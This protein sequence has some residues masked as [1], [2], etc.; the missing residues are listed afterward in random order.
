MKTK[1][2]FL[3][4]ALLL[5]GI[6][7]FSQP[8]NGR[9]RP[10]SLKHR[11]G[12]VDQKISQPLELEKGQKKAVESAFKEF[13]VEMDKLMDFSVQPPARP[14]KAKVD[15]LA[16]IRDEQVKKSIP[17]SKFA[18]YLELELSTRPKDPCEGRPELRG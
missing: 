14:E 1:A 15:A 4:I 2:V 8:E 12:M 3:S 7:C 13:F 11:L 18:K 5:S 6:I 16:K 9:M 10:P 17:E